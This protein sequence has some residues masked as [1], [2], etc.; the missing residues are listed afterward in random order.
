M[1]QEWSKQ[2]PTESGWYWHK[3]EW[4][5]PTIVFVYVTPSCFSVYVNDIADKSLIDYPSEWKGPILLDGG[6]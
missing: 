5:S 4:A 1:K 3:N 6:I 2:R